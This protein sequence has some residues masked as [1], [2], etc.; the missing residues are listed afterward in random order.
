MF[1]ILI[2]NRYQKKKLD[3]S[4]QMDKMNSELFSTKS[5]LDHEIQWRDHAST[6]HHQLLKDKRQLISQ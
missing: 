3:M 2:R 4:S 5:K 1:T 6:V